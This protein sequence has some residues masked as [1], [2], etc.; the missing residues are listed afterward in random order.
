MKSANWA[1]YVSLVDAV[2]AC[3]FV[4]V[5]QRYF[6]S[7]CSNMARFCGIVAALASCLV[8]LAYW[9][10]PRN[11]FRDA[12]T[13][14]S[15]RYSSAFQ[16]INLEAIDGTR[17]GPKFCPSVTAPRPSASIS[18]RSMVLEAGASPIESHQTFGPISYSVPPWNTQQ[19]ALDEEFHVLDGWS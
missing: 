11:R 15:V 8:S 16:R 9:H 1:S 4:V 14:L 5:F 12:S 18:R 13:I 19:W 2:R 3:H 17:G 10:H 6:L 7:H